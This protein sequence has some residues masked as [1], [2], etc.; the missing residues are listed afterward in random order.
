[1]KKL[2][3]IPLELTKLIQN[4]YEPAG[5]KITSPAECE[6]ESI[7]YGACRFGLNGFNIAF[8]TAKI[9]P[10]KLGR[11]VT[12]WKRPTQNNP[13]IPLDIS[14]NI[15]FV[16]VS[17]TENAYHGQF[18]FSQKTLANQGILSHQSQGGKLAF[19]VYP[20]WVK[21][22]A[23]AAIKTQQWQLQHFFLTSQK[24]GI[25]RLC[26]LLQRDRYRIII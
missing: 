19:R 16:I 15:D 4:V 24:E 8:R 22:E 6:T 9:T 7:E 2:E 11:F 25:D 14:D 21:P 13:I 23:K 1:M 20:S 10:K 26:N 5:L 17:V 18:I 12:L 3:P